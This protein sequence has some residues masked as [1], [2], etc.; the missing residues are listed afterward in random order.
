M[1][2]AEGWVR[3]SSCERIFYAPDQL[4][5]GFYQKKEIETP[6][7]HKK[8]DLLFSLDDDSETHPRAHDDASPDPAWELGTEPSIQSQEPLEADITSQGHDRQ[9]PVRFASPDPLDAIESKVDP[10]ALHRV[11]VW[12]PKHSLP[13]VG[14]ARDAHSEAPKQRNK[15]TRKLRRRSSAAPS[16]AITHTSEQV[17]GQPRSLWMKVAGILVL[18]CGVLTTTFIAMYDDWS[19]QPFMRGIYTYTCEVVG[20]SLPYDMYPVLMDVGA[21]GQSEIKPGVYR[22]RG[23]VINRAYYSQPLPVIRLEFIDLENKIHAMRAFTPDV[24]AGDERVLGPNQSRPIVLEV[25]LIDPVPFRLVPRFVLDS[26]Y[27]DKA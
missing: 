16:R 22:I 8:T 24:Y 3:C 5:K 7:S 1:Q 15:H 11:E 2:Q 14:D 27:I 9:T 6:R 21:A 23:A 12:Q 19:R 18:V 25:E 10:D 20:C 26:Y 17:E 13:L 4:L